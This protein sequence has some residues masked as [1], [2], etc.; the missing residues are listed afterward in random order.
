[1]TLYF[2][3]TI[4]AES[5]LKFRCIG[6]ACIFFSKYIYVKC[7]NCMVTTFHRVTQG[8]HVAVDVVTTC[9]CI[10]QKQE[11][12]LLSHIHRLK[13]STSTSTLSFP[14]SSKNVGDVQME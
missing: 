5:I 4:H 9:N 8:S 6:D 11:V 10:G 2:D 12:C 13:I 3:I 1:M 14:S 7:V